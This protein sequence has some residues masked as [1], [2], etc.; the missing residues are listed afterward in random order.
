MPELLVAGRTETY[1]LLGPVTLDDLADVS[2]EADLIVN[3]DVGRAASRMGDVTGD[4]LADL[5]FIRSGPSS[6]FVL[7][8]IAGGLGGGVELPRE[9]TR[10]W[11]EDTDDVAGQTR[12]RQLVR[13]EAGFAEEGSSLAVLNWNDDRFADVLV[14]RQTALFGNPTLGY[15]LS[16]KELWDDTHPDPALNG[17]PGADREADFFALATLL[18]DPTVRTAEAQARLADGGGPGS[19]SSRAQPLSSIRAIVAG[20]VNGDGLDDV[21]LADSGF[22]FFEPQPGSAVSLPNVGRA[23]LVQGRTATASVNIGTQSHLIIQD[24]SLGADLSA[25]GD[26]NRDGYDDFAVSG[27]REGRRSG[28]ADTTREGGLF[29][30][31]GQESFGALATEVTPADADITVRRTARELLPENFSFEGV[32]QATGGDF[33]ADGKMDL[34]VG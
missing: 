16:G 15:V 5:V 10:Q 28:D 19:I 11:V 14:L 21:L 25:L 20:D 22:I 23:Y 4:G 18:A 17:G 3:S 2:D 31:F 6:T 30:F 33:N 13:A 24:F 9:I 27:S 26:L 29:V 1:V 12:V 34:A 32:L 8:V 7:T